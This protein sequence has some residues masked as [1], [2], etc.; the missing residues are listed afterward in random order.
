ME[1][2]HWVMDWEGM[3]SP[4]SLVSLLDKNFF[5]KWLQVSDN[6]YTVNCTPNRKSFNFIKSFGFCDFMCVC[7]LLITGPV[8]MV[9]QQSQ[10]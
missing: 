5:T 6:T 4:S 2:F 9:E 10:L 3:L 1:P 8:F 7:V